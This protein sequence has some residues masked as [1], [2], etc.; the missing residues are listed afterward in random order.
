MKPIKMRRRLAQHPLTQPLLWAALALTP[1]TVYAECTQD[2]DCADGEICE[3][4]LISVGECFIDEDGEEVCTGDEE[5]E[6]VEIILPGGKR[7]TTKKHY[8]TLFQHYIRKKFK[9]A[10]M[11]S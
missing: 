7:K 4:A 2:S 5:I 3:S 9:S 1:T 11:S 8:P 10:L 6:E